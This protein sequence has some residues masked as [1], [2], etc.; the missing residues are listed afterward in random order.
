MVMIA[1]FES[2]I[3]SRTEHDSEGGADQSEDEHSSVLPHAAGALEHTQ[4]LSCLEELLLS[5][6]TILVTDISPSLHLELCAEV[7]VQAD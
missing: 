6:N 5:K 1:L 7:G 3:V 4:R 2:V